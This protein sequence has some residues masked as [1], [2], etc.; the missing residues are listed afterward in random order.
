[1]AEFQPDAAFFRRR[2]AYL[3]RFIDGCEQVLA[4]ATTGNKLIC[5]RYTVGLPQL[6][7]DAVRSLA[8]SMRQDRD[9][10]ASA[11]ASGMSRWAAARLRKRLSAARAR[12][13][14]GRSE[15]EGPMSR[16]PAQQ[17]RCW[18]RMLSLRRD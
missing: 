6:S 4:H 2:S 17:A 12:V 9:A 16:C 7:A 18:Q 13:N 1:M 8:E 3:T 11:V 15:S 5:T 10:V 14:G